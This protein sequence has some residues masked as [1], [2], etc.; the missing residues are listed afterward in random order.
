MLIE[1]LRDLRYFVEVARCRSFSAAAVR[2]SVSSGTMSKAVARLEEHMRT[3]LFIRS[4]RT[5]R[6]TPE[7][8][9]LFARVDLACHALDTAWTDR[10]ADNHSVSGTVYLSTFS[11]YGRTH[12]ARLLP[13]FLRQYPD[14][15]VL[16]S[17]HDNWRS[18]SRDRS[19]IRITW[20][21]PLDED[22]VAQPLAAQQ[23]IMVGGPEYLDRCGTPTNVAELESHACIG[24]IGA[25]GS[26]IHWHFLDPLGTRHEFVPKSQIA[27]MDEMSLAIDFALSNMGLTLVDRND[28]DEKLRAARLVRVM[29]DHV[30]TT[31]NKDA[32]DMILQY[33]PRH[34]LSRPAGLLVDHILHYHA[35]QG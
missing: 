21:E 19:D 5:L 18:T 32:Q 25:T 7:G 20:N 12:L 11:I 4:H 6:L 30:I 23:F 14:I 8:E 2:L 34:R 10:G 22:K 1:E 33:R 3:A 13:A 27:L 15:E 31:R 16:V 17:V 24:G 28:V 29:D 26:R 35:H 9:K